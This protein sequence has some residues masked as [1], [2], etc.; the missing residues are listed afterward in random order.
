MSK[1][2]VIEQLGLQ[3][4]GPH[5]KRLPELSK[6][7]RSW[8]E[9]LVTSG[10]Y[11]NAQLD[12]LDDPGRETSW[13]PQPLFGPLQTVGRAPT[14][15]VVGGVELWQQQRDKFW[16]LEGL[17]R[18]QSDEYRGLGVDVV[19]AAIARW[20]SDFSANGYG[21]RVHAMSSEKSAVR[22]WTRYLG[23]EPN[24]SDAYVKSGVHRFDAVGWIIVPTN[25]DD[26][27][28]AVAR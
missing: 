4:F 18:D 11:T 19:T 13:A 1:R 12:A 9:R 22:W 5:Y 28:Q 26:I 7:A 25:R 27:G 16:F 24:F 17:I 6:L 23:R 21:L 8:Q 10:I 3:G 2:W 20:R 15:A 14:G